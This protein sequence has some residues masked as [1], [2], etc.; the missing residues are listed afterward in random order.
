VDAAELQIVIA[1][2]K[3]MIRKQADELQAARTEITGLKKQQDKSK[4]DK[5]E[6]VEIQKRLEALQLERDN[7]VS[8]LIVGLLFIYS[9]IHPS[10]TA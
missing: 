3:D 9:S 10:I 2:L 6:S 1:S 5:A 4:S 7:E 8:S